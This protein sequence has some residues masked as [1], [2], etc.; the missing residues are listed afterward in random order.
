MPVSFFRGQVESICDQLLHHCGLQL[1]DQ[2]LDARKGAAFMICVGIALC[3][4]I[5]HVHV[6]R[7]DG[8]DG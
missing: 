1:Q 5:L 8:S 4:D 2:L 6:L 7:V 3:F